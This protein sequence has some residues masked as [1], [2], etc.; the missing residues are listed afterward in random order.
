MR[1]L[2]VVLVLSCSSPSSPPDVGRAPDA[3]PDVSGT[4]GPDT[5][6]VP[7]ETAAADIVPRAVDTAATPPSHIARGLQYDGSIRFES[8]RTV[9]FAAVG[10]DPVLLAPEAATIIDVSATW[11]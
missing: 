8:L 4:S 3:G 10:D 9:A 6:P 2:G 11:W 5:S 7:G 1:V